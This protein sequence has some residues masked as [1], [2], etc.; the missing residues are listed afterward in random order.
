MLLGLSFDAE[1][2]SDMFLQN[3]CWFSTEYAALYPKTKNIFNHLC[4]NLRSCL[5]D[6]YF[7]LLQQPWK[8][9]SFV[10]LYC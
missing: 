2:G 4:G 1:D 9:I 7:R 5:I 8:E 3:V 6:T 10:E